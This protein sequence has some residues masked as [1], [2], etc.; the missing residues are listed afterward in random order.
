MKSTKTIIEE[1]RA[2]IAV[3]RREMADLRAQPVYPRSLTR[4]A[5]V[6]DCH[7]PVAP[8]VSSSTKQVAIVDG[9]VGWTLEM[10]CGRMSASESWSASYP[11]VPEDDSQIVSGRPY[12]QK[13]GNLITFNS[14]HSGSIIGT[15]IYPQ[16]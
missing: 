10:L 14:R 13:D 3:L 9:A 12:R 2:E 1:L 5:S 7:S 8:T 4:V 15:Y 16:G 6:S 11:P